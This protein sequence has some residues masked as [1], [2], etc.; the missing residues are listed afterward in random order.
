MKGVAPGKTALLG[1]I[2]ETA[3]DFHRLRLIDDATM[4]QYDALCLP[5]VTDF[6]GDK[7]RLLRDRYQLSQ[8]VLASLLNTS[9]TTVRR[10]EDDTQ[11]PKGPAQKLL[12]LLERKGLETLL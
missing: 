7:I 1:A 12:D 8:A 2:H 4:Q 3:G 10:W 6:D 11:H 9:L 5:P